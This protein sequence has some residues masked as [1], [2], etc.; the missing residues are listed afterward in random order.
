MRIIVTGGAGFIGSHIVDEYI[1]LGHEVVVIDNLSS[2]SKKNLNKKAK[3][4]L[5][6]INKLKEI[7][8][9]FKKE[10]PDIVNHHAA[11]IEVSK[12]L[13]DPLPTIKTNVNGT[14]NLLLTARD[15]GVKKFI[16]ASTGG[17][18]YGNAKKRPTDENS[19]VNPLSPY[20]LSKFLA[21]ESIK[22]YSNHYKF[23][24]LILRYSN[25]YG[26]RQGAKG[27]AGV[28]SIFS[29]LIRTGKTP[30]IFGDGSKT[31]DYVYVNDVVKA[32]ILGLSRGKNVIL[33]IGTGKETSD[34]N[35][36][37]TIAG[38]MDFNKKPLSKPF[39][40]GEVNK[41]SLNSK[42]AGKILGWK[43]KISFKDGIGKTIGKTWEK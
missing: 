33:N 19:A 6:D 5:A 8:K 4:Y 26:P 36:Y 9:I 18:I 42:K 43:A 31:R 23:E 12:S 39:R 14:L 38:A 22:Y 7:Q 37:Y 27:E 16:F 32:N 1:S 35:V 30:G 15:A 21:E 28:V 29:N 20:G 17:A 11:L 3:F 41:S 13:R 2:G 40:K 25:V 10:R 34:K 24:Y